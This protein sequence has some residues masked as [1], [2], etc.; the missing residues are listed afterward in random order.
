LSQ[1]KLDSIFN[2]I[3]SVKSIRKKLVTIESLSRKNHLSNKELNLTL[4]KLTSIKFRYTEPQNQLLLNESIGNLYFKQ[5]KANKAL[6]SYFNLLKLSEK[7]KD[8]FF[9]GISHDHI[10]ETYQLLENKPFAQKHFYYALNY[11]EKTDSLS[12]LADVYNLLGT[13]FKNLKLFDSS[14]KYHDKSLSLRIKTKNK[15]GISYSYNNMA[16]VYLKKNEYEKAEQYLRRSLEIKRSLNDNKG[17]AGS[18]INLG[19]V[20]KKQRQFNKAQTFYEE[21]IT[22]ALSAKAGNFYRTGILN[23]AEMF[24]EM[25]DYKNSAIYYLKNKTISD[26]LR[27]EET[28]KQIAELT[29]QYEVDRKDAEILIQQEQLRAQQAENTKQKFLIIASGVAILMML[30]TIF[31]VYRS[32]KLNKLNSLK[33]SDK[34]KEIEEKNKEIADSINYAKSIQQSLLISKSQLDKNLNNYFILYKPK[35]IVSGD[36]YW[37]AETENGFIFACLDCTGH[38]VPGAFMSL[39]GKENLD[40]AILKTCNPGEILH[41]L[42]KG[43]KKSLN[44]ENNNSR[45]GMD[46]AIIFI[47]KSNTNKTKLKYA[48]ANRPLYIVRKNSTTLD[49]I[50]PTKQ[51]I[52][53]LTNSNHDF[54]EHELL[55]TTGDTIFLTTDGYADQFGH[56]HNKKLTTKRFKELLKDI[57]MQDLT[58]QKRHLEDFFKVWLG[59]KEQLDDLLVV[60]IK[61]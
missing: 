51:A 34:N 28:N 49:E 6:E 15:K 58:D 33:L 55:L 29:A 38:G 18:L 2:S 16:L 43:V 42:N 57:S 31:F 7:N 12:S 30:I 45:D 53:G 11:L 25:G 1:L 44:Q 8:L 35:D 9:M 46:V 54:E 39:I 59:D 5:N 13:N 40:K 22:F 19:E 20:Y 48:G 61:I 36:F 14:L 60:G 21:G 52:G 32:Y 37:G 41:E 23:M 27:D 10:A 26:S 24:F 56:E 4:D 47:E 3:D 17:I 50:K